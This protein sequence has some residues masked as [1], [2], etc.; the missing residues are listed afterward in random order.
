MEL[1]SHWQ[2]LVQ[3]RSPQDRRIIAIVS[4][5]LLVGLFGW[6]VLA[7]SAAR[8]GLTTSVGN[9]R[10]QAA[11]LQLQAIEL[12]DLRASPALTSSAVDLRTLVQTAVDAA[13]LAPML[14][15]LEAV[16]NDQVVAGFG[17]VP[18]A[19]WLQWTET[20]RAQNIRLDSARIETLGIPGQVSVTATLIRARAQ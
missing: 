10:M 1:K 20:L 13:A 2:R 19:Q 8:S 7:A 14:V 15:Q 5:V 11:T 4:G 9:L 17:A 18:F 3:S 6:L 12:A 16:S